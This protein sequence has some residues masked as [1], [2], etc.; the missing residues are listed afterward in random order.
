MTATGLLNLLFYL[1]NSTQ[2]FTSILIC[3]SSC[4]NLEKHKREGRVMGSKPTGCM[5]K[6][7]T[8]KKK[9]YIYIYIS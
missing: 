3:L 8:L 5:C 7:I 6:L 2:I 4:I 9:I 1:K